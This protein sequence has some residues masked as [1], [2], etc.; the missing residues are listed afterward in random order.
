MR[1]ILNLLSL[2]SG[3]ILFTYSAKAQT[4]V[5]EITNYRAIVPFYEACKDSAQVHY[6]LTGRISG[7]QQYS[8]F[9][10]RVEFTNNAGQTHEEY[11]NLQPE[12]SAFAS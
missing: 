1:R 4:P 7:H 9:Q 3:L 2:A 5:I 10:V 6:N 11:V 8:D 12:D